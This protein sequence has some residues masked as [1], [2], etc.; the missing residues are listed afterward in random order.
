MYCVTF[1]M[2]PARGGAISFFVFSLGPLRGDEEDGEKLKLFQALCPPQPTTIMIAI[3]AGVIAGTV[4]SSFLLRLRCE[5]TC[6]FISQKNAD[7]IGVFIGKL[8]VSVV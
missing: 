1:I 8:N 4:S 2:A 6:P 5:L 3:C 7:L